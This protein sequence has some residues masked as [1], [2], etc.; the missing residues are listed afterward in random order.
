MECPEIVYQFSCR[1]CP[2]NYIG[3]AKR[4]LKERLNDHIKNKQKNSVVTLHKK[5]DHEFDWDN[6]KILDRES[7]YQKR[8]ISEML[9]INCNENT[10]NK[11]EDIKSL[12]RIYNSLSNY[13]K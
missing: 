1:G 5:D 7:N 4:A 12:S 10:L 11:K 6:V 3:E 9:F 8:L 13:L 2:A